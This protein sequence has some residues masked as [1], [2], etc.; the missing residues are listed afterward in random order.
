MTA[1]RVPHTSR[2]RTTSP[3]A[4]SRRTSRGQRGPGSCPGTRP[5]SLRSRSEAASAVCAAAGVP[6]DLM[7][8]GGDLAWRKAQGEEVLP[9]GD[10]RSR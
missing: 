1:K 6:R 8:C 2:S 4:L 10:A 3:S 7:P 9:D 5:I